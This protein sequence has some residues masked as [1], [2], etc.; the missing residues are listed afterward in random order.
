MPDEHV[1][2]LRVDLARVRLAGDG[3]AGVEAHL[4]GD[5]PF[6]PADLVVVAVE[7]LQ[8]A[9]CVPVVPFTPRALSVVEAMLDLRQV[10]HEVVGTRAARACRRSSAAPAASA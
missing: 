10:E 7:Q 4:L 9:A 3:V 1:E 5:E 2:N 6:E 8:E